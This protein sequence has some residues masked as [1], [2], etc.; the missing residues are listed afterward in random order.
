MYAGRIMEVGTV[1]ELFRNPRHAY[2]AGLLD[3]IPGTGATRQPLRS[4]EGTP[5]S[6]LE[7]PDSCAFAPRC[8]FATAACVDG[9]PPLQ[10]V[11]PDHL[12]AC[13]HHDRVAASRRGA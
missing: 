13:V 6:P 7:L 9:R 11:G 12:S 3:S 4:I 2:S 10:R 1:V 5:P 8:R